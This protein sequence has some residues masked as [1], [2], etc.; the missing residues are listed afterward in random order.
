MTIPVAAHTWKCRLPH[1]ADIK[2]QD[3]IKKKVVVDNAKKNISSLP[4][5]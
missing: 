4:S 5:V 2:N 1:K 3:G